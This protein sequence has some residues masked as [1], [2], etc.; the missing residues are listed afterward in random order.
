M[1]LKSITTGD[2]P[3]GGIIAWAGSFNGVDTLANQGR[4]DYLECNGQEV[5]D[6]DSP[7]NGE[8]L[9]NLNN[10]DGSEN[11]FLRGATTSGGSSGSTMHTHTI[12]DSTDDYSPAADVA[13]GSGAAAAATHDHNINVTTGSASNEP[14]YYDVIWL[15]RIK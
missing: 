13:S 12:S 14:P 7:L 2:V 4:T 15:M 5:S 3:I 6:A 11:F 1:P 8:T 9:P 10:D